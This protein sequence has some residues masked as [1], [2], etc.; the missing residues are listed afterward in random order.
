MFKELASPERLA[1]GLKQMVAYLHANGVT[2]YNEPGSL[3][4]PDMCS[5]Y[6]PH[7]VQGR[8]RIWP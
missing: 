5:A 6:R 2:A 7:Q 8:R 1:F 3:Y 4:T